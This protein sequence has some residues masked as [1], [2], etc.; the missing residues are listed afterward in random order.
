[1]SIVQ[2]TAKTNVKRQ[3][4]TAEEARGEAMVAA[5]KILLAQGP[6]AIT[7]QAVATDLG[8]SHTNLIHHFGSAGALQMALMREMVAELTGSIE[9]AVQRLR[10]GEGSMRDFVD[11]V[12]NAFDAGGAGQLT[13]W[14]MVSGG[15]EH[16]APVGEVV[17]GYVHNVERGM[18][19]ASGALHERIT[20]ATLLVTIAAFGDA[21]I[22]ENL[23]GMV[24]RSRDSMR[25]IVER[26]LPHILLP[27]PEQ[28]MQPVAEQCIEKE[29]GH[30]AS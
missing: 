26:L 2:K 14:I 6:N 25:R 30:G 24:G 9:S 5:R 10:A 17:R 27:P 15:G 11:I 29:R 7:L 18:E 28:H 12:F 23:G 21:I 19:D 13:A 1:M 8:M 16:L 4:R 3:R 20:S 22:G